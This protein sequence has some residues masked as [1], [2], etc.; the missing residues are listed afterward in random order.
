[1]LKRMLIRTYAEF[2]VTYVMTGTCWRDAPGPDIEEGNIGA[3]GGP[4]PSCNK[5]YCRTDMGEACHVSGTNVT[6]CSGGGAQ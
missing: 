1:M 3:C 2:H 6:D 4:G 5:S